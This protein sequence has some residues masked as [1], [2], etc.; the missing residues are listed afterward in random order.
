MPVAL[1]LRVLG[2]PAIRI[3]FEHCRFGASAGS[4]TYHVLAV[5]ALGLPAYVATEVLGRGLIALR[6]TR[7]PLFTNCVQIAGRA[8]IM[9]WLISSQGA[10]AIPI[11]FATMAA[12]EAVALGVALALRVRRSSERP[13]SPG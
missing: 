2:R 11:A 4:L 3:L 12:L 7:T 8:G 6:D 1:C 13:L 5:Y 10:I 9:A